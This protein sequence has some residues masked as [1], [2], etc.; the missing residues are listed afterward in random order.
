MRRQS[1]AGD[2]RIVQTGLL[3]CLLAVTAASIALPLTAATP[4]VR[5]IAFAILK[6]S[7]PIGQHSVTFERRGEEL[8]VDIA[9]DIQIRFAFL[10]LF[11]YR[12][13]NREVWRGGQL[14][15]LD[16]WTDDDG[17]DYRVRARSTPAGLRVEGSGG[18]FVA[19][20]GIIPTSYWNPATIEQTRLLDTQSGR[21]LEVTIQSFDEEAMSVGSGKIPVRK[22]AVTGDLNLDVWYTPRGEW[23]KIAF[24]ARGS[25]IDYA[26]AAAWAQSLGGSG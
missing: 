9:I 20:K 13:E 12:H 23:T 14:V 6:D 1:I 22:Y 25:T 21:L 19:P 2:R 26:P 15:S 24:Q 8:L 17:T 5:Q 7:D 4:P 11:R 18:T 16:T 10:T 3:A